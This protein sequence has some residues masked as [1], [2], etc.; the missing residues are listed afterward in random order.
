MFSLREK[1]L[2]Y[3][4]F[5][6]GFTI[7]YWFNYLTMYFLILHTFHLG[8]Y[9]KFGWSDV[10]FSTAFL[11]YKADTRNVKFLLPSCFPLCLFTLFSLKG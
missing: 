8:F 4:L 9:P 5:I 6:I 10:T 1:Q 2:C 7:S 3:H 11:I